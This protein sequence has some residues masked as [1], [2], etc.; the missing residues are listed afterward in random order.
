MGKQRRERITKI[1]WYHK[2]T[3]KFFDERKI[4]RMGE[5]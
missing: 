2:E 5:P 3:L 1:E 4:Q